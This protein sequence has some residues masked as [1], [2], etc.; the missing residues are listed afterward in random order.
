MSAGEDF[1][2]G[3]LYAGG[4]DAH[5]AKAATPTSGN[6][7]GIFDTNCN[8]LYDPASSLD[9]HGGQNLL[10]SMPTQMV[11]CVGEV[12]DN[13]LHHN[14]ELRLL[15]ALEEQGLGEVPVTLG[16]E[17]FHATAE[18]R[19]ALQDYVF[20]DDDLTTLLD[21]TSW[22]T[23]WGWPIENYA[24]LLEFA[25]AKGIRVIGL[26][27][28]ERVSVFVR[29]NGI[30]GLVDKPGFPEM[31][32]SNSKHLSLFVNTFV[33]NRHGQM[34][35]VDYTMLPEKLRKRY[36]EQVFREEWIAESIAK[37]ALHH[38]GRFL[39]VVGRNHVAGRAGVP[40][41]VQR[42][43]QSNSWSRPFTVVLQEAPGSAGSEVS[44]RPSSDVADWVW[45]F[46][47][48]VDRPEYQALLY[49]D[50]PV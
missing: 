31:D 7:N 35:N 48:P 15:R 1:V 32:F 34:D 45:Y 9:P 43:L 2:R 40:D 22:R 28:P 17:M 33:S 44:R 42:R 39:A 27:A 6:C 4:V 8:Q 50:P 41:R 24:P 12:H 10:N 13:K 26:N 11:M 20:G 23:T 5:Y 18:H 47:Q 29:R 21:R 38:Q 37:S 30:D 14:A 19:E 25:K 36:E 49:F 46:D 3:S 16:L